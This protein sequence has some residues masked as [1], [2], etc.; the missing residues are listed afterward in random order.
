MNL[1]SWVLTVR[2]PLGP[3]PPSELFL[4]LEVSSTPVP[5]SGE[6]LADSQLLWTK[7]AD[8]VSRVRRVHL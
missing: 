6:P 8:L 5:R 4:G 7:P 2:Y 3:Q 1:P